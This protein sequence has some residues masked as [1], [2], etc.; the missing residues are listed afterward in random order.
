[1]LESRH[2]A[3]KPVQAVAMSGYAPGWMKDRAWPLPHGRGWQW[4][5]SFRIT[6]LRRSFESLP[7]AAFLEAECDEKWRC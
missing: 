7:L 1:M 5:C 4:R 3:K 2:V 6:G